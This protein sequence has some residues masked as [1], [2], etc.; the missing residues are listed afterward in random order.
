MQT[1]QYVNFAF[2]D[3]LRALVVAWAC[4]CLALAIRALVGAVL[5][6]CAAMGGNAGEKV[7]EARR[8]G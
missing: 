3:A 5:E 1:I 4:L 2:G 7:L 8:R 6:V